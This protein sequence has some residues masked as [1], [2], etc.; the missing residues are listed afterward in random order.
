MFKK[1]AYVLLDLL[2][3]LV[4][5]IAAGQGPYVELPD[6]VE[7]GQE[8]EFPNEAAIA[9]ETAQLMIR[10]IAERHKDDD[11]TLRD[12]HPFAHGCVHGSFDVLSQLPAEL[13]HGVFAEAAS[14]PVWIRFSN[15]STQRK[16]DIEGDIRGMGIKLTGV[17]GPKIG[18]EKNTQDFLVI[19]NPVMPAGDPGEYL[20]LFEAALSGKPMSY[21]LNGMP[22]NWK[23]SAFR[24]VIQIRS[25][26]IPSMLSTRYWSTVPFRLGP[27]QAVKYSTRPCEDSP[28]AA[29]TMPEYPGDRYLRETMIEQLSAGDACFDFMI[30]TQGDPRMMPVEDPAVE[31]DENISPFVT[32]AKVRIP[33]QRFDSPAQDRFCENLTLNP[34]NSLEAHRPLGGINRVRQAV[35]DRIAEYRL[36]KNQVQRSEP[37]GAERF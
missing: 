23:L 7:A 4:L 33:A 36:G 1:I 35:Y 14:Y 37:T 25:R 24:K 30:Q 31:W 28:T 2:V 20:A 12:A 8:Y 9:E 13:R 10:S 3:L 16:P 17:P 22:W 27:D 21:F 29:A 18:P 5:S 15:G 26:E 6:N 34:F 19:T 32:A 11:R